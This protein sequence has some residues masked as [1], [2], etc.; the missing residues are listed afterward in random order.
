MKLER[1]LTG[2]K[3]CSPKA[4]SQMSTAAIQFAFEDARK[5]ILTLARLL[6]EAGYP[7]RGTEEENRDMIAFAKRVQSLIPHSEAVELG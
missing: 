6:C 4:M 3:D 5:D 7:H 2:W 1:K